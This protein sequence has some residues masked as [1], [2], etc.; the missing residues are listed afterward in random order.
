[1]EILFKVNTKNTKVD[2][3]TNIFILVFPAVEYDFVPNR[4]EVSPDT[5]VHIQ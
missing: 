5:Y 4:L 3:C 1:V 2:I